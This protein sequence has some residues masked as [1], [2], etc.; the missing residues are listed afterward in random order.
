MKLQESKIE[1]KNFKKIV[2]KNNE[3]KKEVIGGGF[4]DLDIAKKEAKKLRS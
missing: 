3:R 1:I 2:R 4:K